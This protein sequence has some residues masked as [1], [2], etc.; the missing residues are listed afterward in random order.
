MKN[1]KTRPIAWLAVIFLSLTGMDLTVGKTPQSRPNS[2][3]PTRAATLKPITGGFIQYQGWMIK[4]QRNPI[5]LDER[6]WEGE[7][8]AMRSA[9]MDTVVIQRLEAD[10]ESYVGLR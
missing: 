7:I 2:V 10:G 6:A 9:K 3:A 4:N 8:E 1:I 5:G